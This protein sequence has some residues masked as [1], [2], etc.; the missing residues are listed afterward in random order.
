MGAKIR[1]EA[2]GANGSVSPVAGIEL[3]D[4]RPATNAGN[5][6]AFV[7]INSAASPSMA[8][9]SCSSP[10]NPPGWPCPTVRTRELAASS[11]GRRLWSWHQICAAA[12]E[13]RS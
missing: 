6:R 8:A 10:A 3:L 11:S 13:T 2:S 5:V 4:I 12:S 7:T 1:T 9:R